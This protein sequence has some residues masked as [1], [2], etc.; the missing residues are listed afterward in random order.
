MGKV[1]DA[2]YK[3]EVCK[4]EV[5]SGETVPSVSRELGISENT[6][7]TWVSRYRQNSAVPFVGNGH[8]KPEDAELK[9]LLQENGELR[10]ENE[11]LRANGER[12]SRGLV[13]RIMREKGLRSKVVMKYKAATNSNHNLPIAENLLNRE[14]QASRFNEKWVSVI[15]Y[16]LPLHINTG[17]SFSRKK[18][19]ISSLC[20]SNHAATI[21]P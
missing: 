3:T 7:Y 12:V 6:L 13:A 2:A 11:M 16:V 8:I 18:T 19:S 14:F 5:E 21:F 4:R 9:R 20:F 1:Y 10:E 17:N 15:T